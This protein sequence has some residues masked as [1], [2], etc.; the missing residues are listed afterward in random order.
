MA[1]IDAP[2]DA[3]DFSLID[4][5]VLAEINSPPEKNRFFRGLRAWIGFAQIG[6]EYERAP[7]AAGMT[8]YPFLKLLKL[9]TDGIFNFSTTPLTV[10]FFLGMAISLLSFVAL[11]AVIFL[12]IADVRM[13]GVRW[14]D[15]QGFAST[16]VT[17]LFI[18][19]IQLICT[20]ILGEYIGRI[21]QEVKA[22]PFFIAQ[23][24]PKMPESSVGN[25]DAGQESAAHQLERTETAN[26]V[27]SEGRSGSWR[28]ASDGQKGCTNRLT[29]R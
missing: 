24:D 23:V 6:V 14:N 4:R 2:L 13:F 15:V 3:G 12:R 7:R 21:Y 28:S 29:K 17:I 16:I 18:G 1:S 9:A 8:K 10:V 22:P 11:V 20:G 26:S 5:R 19:R 25:I 27:S